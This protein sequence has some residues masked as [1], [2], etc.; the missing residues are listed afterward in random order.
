MKCE[1]E[2]YD[3]QNKTKRT[4]SFLQVQDHS[5]FKGSGVVGNRE[6]GLI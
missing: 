5:N 1:R 2:E 6:M 3:S 4:E